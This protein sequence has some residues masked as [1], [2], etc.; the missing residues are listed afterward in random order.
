MVLSLL[1]PPAL[2]SLKK[3]EFY[4]KDLWLNP[5]TKWGGGKKT[6]AFVRYS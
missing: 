3:R 5:T 4:Y 2:I 6:H 1:I